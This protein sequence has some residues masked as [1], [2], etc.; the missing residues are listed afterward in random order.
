V[1]EE[2]SETE[3]L[4]EVLQPTVQGSSLEPAKSKDQRPPQRPEPPQT[5]AITAG[6]KATGPGICLRWRL[7]SKKVGLKAKK[8]RLGY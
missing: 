5:P 8:V 7:D 2:F 3:A 6:V 1:P 4:A